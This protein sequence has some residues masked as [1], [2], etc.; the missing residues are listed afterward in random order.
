MFLYQAL[1]NETILTD[2]TDS[3]CIFHFN[4]KKVVN[5]LMLTFT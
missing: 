3:Y 5:S 4:Y 1:E 2:Q